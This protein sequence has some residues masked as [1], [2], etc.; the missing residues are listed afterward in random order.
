MMTVTQMNQYLEEEA[1][2]HTHYP[3]AHF[4]TTGQLMDLMVPTFNRIPIGIPMTM[5]Q[6]IYGEFV[7]S[8]TLLMEAGQKYPPYFPNRNGTDIAFRSPLLY[9]KV[10]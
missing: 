10:T 7:G 2:P 3:I 4:D 9:T 6:L 5:K 1:G 8:S